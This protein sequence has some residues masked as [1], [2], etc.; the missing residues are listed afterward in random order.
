M[1][2]DYYELCTSALTHNREIILQTLKQHP[3]DKVTI[4]YSGGG[5]SGDIE[6]IQAYS[7]GELINL[8][9]IIIHYREPTAEYKD[10]KYCYTLEDTQQS[11]EKSLRYFALTWLGQDHR[12]WEIN[13]GGNGEVNILVAKEAFSLN[14][15]EYYTESNSYEYAL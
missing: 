2:T 11:L 15:T 1:I 10:G 7:S 4:I 3:I 14:H 5:D 13:D 9:D 6:E 8:P 12:G